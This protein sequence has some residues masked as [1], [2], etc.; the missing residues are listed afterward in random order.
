MIDSE[1]VI[2]FVI[3]FI[4]FWHCCTLMICFVGDDGCYT[5]THL[6]ITTKDAIGSSTTSRNGNVTATIGAAGAV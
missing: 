5:T 3:D 1:D 6:T 4:Y 2:S